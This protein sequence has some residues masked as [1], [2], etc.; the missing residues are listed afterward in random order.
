MFNDKGT[1]IRS[2]HRLDLIWEQVSWICQMNI[3]GL[4]RQKCP[5]KLV[6]ADSAV[7]YLA[8]LGSNLD[9]EINLTEFSCPS[10]QMSGQYFKIG[11]QLLPQPLEFNIHKL[12]DVICS[13]VPRTSP[14]ESWTKQINLCKCHNTL[15]ETNPS[16]LTIHSYPFSSYIVTIM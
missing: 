2:A 1:D 3:T 4:G 12:L 14:S 7:L 10:T 6:Q 5:S 9:L 8:V 16:V 13:D 15:I 11:S